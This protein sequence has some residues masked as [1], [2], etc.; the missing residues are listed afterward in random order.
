MIIPS[1]ALPART[2]APT[3]AQE[4]HA[5]PAHAPPRLRHAPRP[6]AVPRQ[7]AT[8]VAGQWKGATG[9]T[10]EHGS[11]T[12][13]SELKQHALTAMTM[14]ATEGQIASSVTRTLTATAA[15]SLLPQ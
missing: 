11:G 7:Q 5:N 8:A 15:I 12:L 3:H 9:Q 2:A 14:I 6:K 10:V 4:A 13:P 1:Q